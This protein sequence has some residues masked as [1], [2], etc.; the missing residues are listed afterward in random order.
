MQ[1]ALGEVL[2]SFASAESDAAPGGLATLL[3]DVLEEVAEVNY[4]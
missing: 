3:A 1:V 4:V 2:A